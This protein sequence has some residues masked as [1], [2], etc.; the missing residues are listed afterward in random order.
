MG[1][2]IIIAIALGILIGTRLPVVIP[3]AYAKY[4]SVSFLAALDSVLG[5][6]YA[7]MEGKYKFIVF[8]TGFITNALL[9]ALL[10]MVGDRLGVDLY[11][12]AIV[13]FGGRI[14]Q[15]LAIIRR[16]ILEGKKLEHFKDEK[17]EE[18]HERT[19]PV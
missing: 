13:V 15:N 17:S 2:L 6:I 4:I 5:A 11:I 16:E 12:A 14:F 18:E 8:S 9:A 19:F 10:T 3:L 1:I 7:G